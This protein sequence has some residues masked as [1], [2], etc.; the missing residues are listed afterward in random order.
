LERV[1]GVQRT[2][3][4]LRDRLGADADINVRYSGTEDKL[5][6][7]VRARAADDADAMAEVVRQ[8]LDRLVAAIVAYVGGPR[9]ED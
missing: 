2:V 4:W 6:L 3:A 1:D 7:S 9:A 5:R 8:G